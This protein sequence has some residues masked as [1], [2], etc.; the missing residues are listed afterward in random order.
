[1]NPLSILSIIY[2]VFVIVLALVYYLVPKKGQWMVLLAG[3][4]AFYLTYGWKALAVLAATSFIVYIAGLHSGD[5]NPAGSRSGAAAAAFGIVI[6]AAILIFM[7]LPG[8]P[9]IGRFSLVVPLGI[10]FYTLQLISYIADV[11]KGSIQPER[12]FFRFFLT[13]SFFPHIMQGPIER[14]GDLNG[15]FREEHRVS[16]DRF[17]DA[18][19]LMAWGYIKKLVIADRAAIFVDHAWES[20]DTTGGSVFFVAALLYSV[21]IYVDFSGCVDIARGTAE[22]FGIKMADNF[23]VPYFSQSVQEFWRRWHI[24]LSSWLR[25]YIYIPLGGNRKGAFRKWL[26]VFLVFFV[27]GLW[28]GSGLTFLLWGLMHA[29]LQLLGYLLMP[30]RRWLRR[31]LSVDMDHTATKIFR[32]VF[33]FLMVTAAWVLFRAPDVIS[34]LKVLGR[35]ALKPTLWNLTDGTLCGYG[36]STST[37]LM[38]IVFIVILL[39]VDIANYKGIVVREAVRKQHFLVR[40]LIYEAA[41]LSVALFG[42]Y[43]LG[44][45]ADA[46]IYMAF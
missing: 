10:S 25:D 37:W 11:R 26:N 14:F 8:N 28:H 7:K 33:T 43:G 40:A 9:L 21:Q 16:W 44:Y 17:V 24:S 20:M 27:S 35:I 5:A 36:L 31:V 4:I 22:V 2:L 12:N 6:P 32:G 46:F 30:L 18:G 1:M 13:V 41:I 3:S 42:V 29:A 15:Q 45:N 34:G 39:F 38:L 23:N 19:L